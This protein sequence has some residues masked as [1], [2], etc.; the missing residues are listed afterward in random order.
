MAASWHTNVESLRA[1]GFCGFQTL[2]E[3]RDDQLSHVPR[4]PNDKGIY[5]ILLPEAGLPVF[6]DKSTGG[7]HKG[8]DPNVD[9]A[10]L[11]SKWVPGAR[12]VYIGQAGGNGSSETLRKRLNTYLRFGAGK[13]AGHWGGRYLWH[14]P[15]SENLLACW[16]VTT[17]ED[18]LDVER[19]MI[20]EFVDA[21]GALPFANL[22]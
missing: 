8:R 12:V 2:R 11:R 22:S 15:Q 9:P 7:D 20:H 4:E 3:L 5:I 10:L 17:G 1:Q 16:K 6:L 13:K 19:R 21:Y 18:P 14:L